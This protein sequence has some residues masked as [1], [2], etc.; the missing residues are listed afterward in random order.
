MSAKYTSRLLISSACLALAAFG[1]APALAQDVAL[2]DNRT[3]DIET[4]I[5]TG[6][7]FNTDV[8]PAKASLDTMEP[9][10]IIN[11]SYIQ[12]SLAGTA[13]YTT[14]LAIAP[15]MSGQDYN[16]PGLS[17]N[18]AKNT[19]RG[20]SD[21]NYVMQYDGIPF[22]DTNGPSHHSE[23]YFPGVTIGSI[24]VDR[25]PGNAG[26]LGAATYGGTVSLF[27]EDM[28]P[29]SHLTGSA[30]YGSWYTEML[31][32]NYQSGDYAVAG[33]NN[34]SLINLNYVG[35]SGYLSLQNTAR[36]NVLVKQ[37]VDI[38]PGWTLT[39]FANYNGLFQ[40]LNDNAG[41]TAGQ[42]FA[43]GETYALQ[44]TNAK[45]PN[46][47]AYNPEAKKTDMDYLRLQGNLGEVTVDDTAYTYAYINKTVSATNIEQTRNDIILGTAEGMGT[48]VNGTK[49]PTDVPGYTKQNAYRVWGNILRV[50]D[51]FSLGWLT[52]EVR[53]GVWWEGSS[54][55]RQR[56]D[57]DLTQCMA[58]N[59]NP[60][61]TS[62]YSDSSLS[63]AAL[64]AAKATS[65]FLG[66][67]YY[68]YREHSDWYQYQPFVELELHPIDGLTITPG[69]KYVDWYHG[70]QAPLEQKLVPV[71]P[72][73]GSF[74]TTHDLPFAMANYKIEQNWSVYAQYA[75][76][77]Y[78]PDISAFESTL[79][80][81][82]APKAETTTNYQFGTV[83]YAN[84][85]TF[86]GD[87]YYIGVNNNYSSQPCAATPSDECFVNTGSAIYKGVEGEGT[88]AFEGD[89]EG[90]SLFASASDNYAKTAGA[91]VKN[92]P[93]WTEATGLVYKGG[94]FKVSLIDKLVGQQYVGKQSLSAALSS[95][96]KLPAYNNMDFKGSW[97][98]GNFELGMAI[99][100]LLQQKNLLTVTVN[101]KAAV[102]ASLF[103]YAGR[104]TSL[105]QYFFAPQRSI[106][107]SI[108][109]HL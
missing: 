6:T 51:D 46:Y 71:V 49:F 20:L 69:F 67:G 15:S 28:S 52:G 88:Y 86:D 61:H 85:F 80:L 65:A 79:P 27:S 40:H 11:K 37:Q 5:V 3:G 50:A 30:T 68:E 81:L 75:Q 102:G 25:G 107:I 31:N 104:G 17:D 39:A 14:I 56:K 54:S 10:T 101:D 108:T 1:A 63:A 60:W 100:N 57:L 22:G 53:A 84:N 105:D 16:G 58:N 4:V 76:G 106:Q 92:A 42:I 41:E 103:D 21:G 109:A 70:A 34:R 73:Y 90:F 82:T 99:A 45:L 44:N 59:C 93:L 89:L 87:V 7:T 12:D 64:G 9:Q 36:Q 77:I 23:S 91:T 55:E 74:T 29:T 95:F 62:Q 33:L 47:A 83:Y 19:L 2:N 26:N 97:T 24:I 94:P 13:D 48:I 35:S 66:D 72:Y 32:G 8:A 78:V 96:Y 43:Y 18:G 98:F 38:A